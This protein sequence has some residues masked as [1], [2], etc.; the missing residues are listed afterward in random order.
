MPFWLINDI[1]IAP[2]VNFFFFS[3][4]KV[5]AS[6]HAESWC[7]ESQTSQCHT[8]TSDWVCC[9]IIFIIWSDSSRGFELVTNMRCCFCASGERDG[10]E[11]ITAG[12]SRL[13]RDPDRTSTG[14]TQSTGIWSRSFLQL[15][16]ETG[17]SVLYSTLFNCEDNPL[18]APPQIKRAVQPLQVWCRALYQVI[19]RSRE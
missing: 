14:S 9:F 16:L 19:T 15:F 5:A 18:I 17:S 8:V 1:F 10:V 12:V 13:S 2:V 7:H 6:N 4:H 11:I 3:L